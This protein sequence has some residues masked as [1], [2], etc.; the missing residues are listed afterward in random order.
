MSFLKKAW[1][2]ALVGLAVICVWTV[3][4]FRL[5]KPPTPVKIY[6]VPQPTPQG[7]SNTKPVIRQD[8][9]TTETNDRQP[10]EI[11]ENLVESDT[12][13]TSEFLDAVVVEGIDENE[14]IG[15]YTL[16]A[17]EASATPQ[18]STE[19]S[20]RQTL[21]NR[22]VEIQAQMEAMARADGSVAPRDIPKSLELFEES[23][24]ISQELGILNSDD[25]SAA[26]RLIERSKFIAS[27][28]TVD[29]KVPV[30]IGLRIADMY[31]KDGNYEAAKKMRIIT[32]YA[33]ENRDE[34]F[35]SKHLEALR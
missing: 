4:H 14:E 25:S 10:S 24:R 20:R 21:I 28:T 15:S 16:D 6:E 9:Q 7:Q 13:L 12:Y 11:N 18:L 5:N 22:Q 34:F 19:E 29:G 27:H 3:L 17:D 32:Q 8:T 1:S 33:L 35:T 30:S 26:F 2:F 23:L 31:E